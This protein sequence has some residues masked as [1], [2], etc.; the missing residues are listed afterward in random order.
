[1]VGHKTLKKYTA[2]MK[3][4]KARKRG[5]NAS[6]YKRKKGYGVSVTKKK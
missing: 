2:K 4:K 5:L 3:A 6:V 1:M